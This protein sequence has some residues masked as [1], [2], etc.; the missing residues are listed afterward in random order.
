MSGLSDLDELAGPHPDWF[1][2]VLAVPRKEHVVPCDGGTLHGF[3]W[4][5]PQK[6]A[7]LFTH[8]MLA[9]ARCWAFVAPLLAENFHLAAIDISGMG[10]SSW[11]ESYDY[12]QRAAETLVFANALEMERP[13]LVCHSFGGSVGLSAAQHYPEAFSSLIVCDMAMLRPEDVAEFEKSREENP[14]FAR[15][16]TAN[17]VYDSLETALGRYRLAP[18][19]PCANDFLVEYMAY[20]SLKKVEGGYVWK[21]DPRILSPDRMKDSGGWASLSTRFAALNMPKA[22][23]HG[24]L[25][26]LFGPQIAQ[27]MRELTEYRVPIVGI[28]QAYHHV[29]LDQPIALAA[30]LNALLQSLPRDATP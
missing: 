25:S 20:H 5:D 7:V 1:K 4:G 19:Q 10:D 24:V 6:P 11:H 27:Y 26:E 3:S 23:V 16:R 28:E 15:E 21:F 14:G 12:E 9:H 2:A 13:Q 22:I 8:G 18:E 17:K 29:M 30:T